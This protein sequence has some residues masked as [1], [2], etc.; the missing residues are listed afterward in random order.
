MTT[1]AGASQPPTPQGTLA[2]ARS[3][4]PALRSGAT[5][6]TATQTVT[7]GGTTEAFRTSRTLQV[8]GVRYR[9]GESDLDSVFPPSGAQGEFGNTL[10]HV[11]LTRPSLPWQRQAD[12]SAEAPWLAV[13]LFDELD[14]APVP[15]PATLAD[16]RSDGGRFFPP[17]T[18]EPGEQDS[19]PVTVIDLAPELFAVLAPSLADL[20]WL[21]HARQTVSSAK[22]GRSRPP[23]SAPSAADRA[24]VIGNRLPA[25]GSVCTAHLVS[26]EGYGP[27]LPGPDGTPGP[28]PTGTT[29]VRLVSLHSWRFTAVDLKQTFQD[30]LLAVDLDPAVLQLPSAELPLSPTKADLAVR[31]AFGLGYTALD[32]ALQ[33]GSTVSWY[34]GPLLPLRAATDLAPPYADPDQLLRYDPTTGL[35]DT[36][37]AAAWQL[38]KLLALHDNSYA[39]A[40][41]R[42]KLTH[43]QQ[44]AAALEAEV[45]EEALPAA[46]RLARFRR[47]VSELVAPAA[48]QLVENTDTGSTNGTTGTD[49]T[50]A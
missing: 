32:H 21:T 16:L 11:V 14:P 31:D 20:P 42:W 48:R 10:P 6:V 23:V 36:T 27:H 5:T 28:L 39:A 44:Q 49:G 40:L 24:V 45:L 37:Y 26:L 17:R 50:G 35:F 29:A 12:P 25:T 8:T 15:V 43:T 1:P 19:E 18:A 7:A 4:V 2:F 34:R 13:L 33:G 30:L 9:L 47:A 3:L 41:Y 38:G 46:D 22:P